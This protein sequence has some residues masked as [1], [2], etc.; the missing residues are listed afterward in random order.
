MQHHTFSIP[1]GYKLEDRQ[2]HCDIDDAVALLSG[3]GGNRITVAYRQESNRATLVKH[4]LVCPHCRS[5]VPAYPRYMQEHFK[6]MIR[7]NALE[8]LD[9]LET[10]SK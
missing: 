1:D 5:V 2:L 6:I 8:A 10:A 3:R 4:R 9:M 7:G